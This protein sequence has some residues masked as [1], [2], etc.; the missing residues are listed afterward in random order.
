ME[1]KQY[2]LET[3]FDGLVTDGAV[4][5]YSLL[6]DQSSPQAL[7]LAEQF[8]DLYHLFLNKFARLTQ[9]SL[10]SDNLEEE[11]TVLLKQLLEIKK[12]LVKSET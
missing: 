1:G 3:V 5:Y 6:R 8:N 9:E 2:Q 7:E 11:M 12:A 4:F 10:V